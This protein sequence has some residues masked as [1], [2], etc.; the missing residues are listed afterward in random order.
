MHDCLT[1]TT[2]LVTRSSESIYGSGSPSISG[3]GRFVA[4]ETNAT[5]L[6][7][8]DTN[9]RS[10]IFVFDRQTGTTER[11]SVA[12]DGAQ[13]DLDSYHPS[14]SG[15]GRYVAFESDASNLVAGDSNA[16]SDIFVYDR[17][18]GQTQRVSIASDGSQAND[19]ST[20]AS[21]SGDG[22]YV[23]FQTPATNLA[24]LVPGTSES[25]TR[26]FRARSRGGHDR[27]SEYSVRWL[28][29]R[30]LEQQ[31]LDQF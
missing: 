23:V 4:F 8:N 28:R 20:T 25:Y 2:E 6:V 13:A 3:D 27:A 18:T 7:P 29:G 30:R 12:S 9:H 1:G 14:I 11:V 17:A 10:D 21:I 15:D 5:D 31:R 22:R 19:E 16:T 24:N 26:H